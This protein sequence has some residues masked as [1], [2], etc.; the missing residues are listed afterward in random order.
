MVSEIATTV[1]LGIPLFWFN[2]RKT[3]ATFTLV[4]GFA[5]IALNQSL[6]LK[7]SLTETVETTFFAMLAVGLAYAISRLLQ[8]LKV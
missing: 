6:V 3:R 4:T 7:S 5:M 1:L 2:R 8:K